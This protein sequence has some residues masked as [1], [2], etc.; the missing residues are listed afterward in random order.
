MLGLLPSGLI[1]TSERTDMPRTSQ[2]RLAKTTTVGH[3]PVQASLLSDGYVI[4]NIDGHK[5][6][7]DVVIDRKKALKFF[8]RCVSQMT[9]ADCGELN[10]ECTCSHGCA[11]CANKPICECL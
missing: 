1:L 9:C 7:Q 8:Q 4:L 5:P 2:K 11:D 10:S 3:W 6:G